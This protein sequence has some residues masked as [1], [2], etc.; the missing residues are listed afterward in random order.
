MLAFDRTAK[1]SKFS[2]FSVSYVGNTMK[3]KKLEV[4]ESDIFFGKRQIF[5]FL[6]LTKTTRPQKVRTSISNL[7]LAKLCKLKSIYKISRE[8]F[9]TNKF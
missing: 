9:L 6:W 8:W 7:G 2:T 5:Y 1:T 4:K 3:I